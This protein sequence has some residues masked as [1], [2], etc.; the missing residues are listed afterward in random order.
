M[1][2][3]GLV[4]TLL[5]ILLNI[6]SYLPTAGYEKDGDFLGYCLEW[7]TRNRPHP[8]ITLYHKLINDQN[9]FLFK[10]ITTIKCASMYFKICVK[11]KK[12]FMD[13][14]ATNICIG[15]AEEAS[16]IAEWRIFLMR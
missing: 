3:L 2:L 11:S 9:D 15:V 16:G 10:A 8:H 1:S 14:L 5:A 13:C 12:G 6:L 4:S 7:P